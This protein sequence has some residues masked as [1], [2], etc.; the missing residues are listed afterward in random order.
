MPTF[1]KEERLCNKRHIFLL[2]KEGQAFFNYPFTV[3]WLMIS[4]LNESNVRLLPAVP[5]RNFKKAV[6]RNKIKRFIR[7]AYRLNKEILIKTAKQHNKN[8][9]I[10]LLYSG[11]KIVPYNEAETKIALIL[12]Q[13]ADSL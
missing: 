9:I 11:K 4:G 12:Q 2:H 6:D 10:T 13:I 7:E 8:I 1:C 5:K 3:K